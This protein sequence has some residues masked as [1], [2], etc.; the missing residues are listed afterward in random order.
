MT[1]SRAERFDRADRPLITD[2]EALARMLA[3]ESDSE[4]V[5]LVLGFL[6]VRRAAYLHRSV[7]RLLTGDSGSYGPQ[8]R[9]GKIYYA[10]T[11]K[12]ATEATR[13]LA[14]QLL[15]EDVRPNRLVRGLKPGAWVEGGR[16]G[17]PDSRLLGLQERFGEGIYARIAG[18]AW[19]LYS[20]DAPQ[21][22]SLAEVPV[23]Q[24]REEPVT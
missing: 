21:V 5:R 6:T 10:S 15:S 13:L 19:Y 2:E 14:Q 4:D 9:G 12:P 18:S 22:A 8:K 16:G 17:A 24:A 11:R 1:E 23:M 3:S 20:E 7:A